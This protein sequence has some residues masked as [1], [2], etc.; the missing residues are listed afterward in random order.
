MPAPGTFRV[1]AVRPLGLGRKRLHF[2]TL[3]TLRPVGV[4]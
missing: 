1:C 2:L 3:A 4:R